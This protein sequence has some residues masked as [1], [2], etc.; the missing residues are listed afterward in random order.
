MRA[1]LQG[2]L[3]LA[4]GGD[5][6]AFGEQLI[7]QTRAVARHRGLNLAQFDDFFIFLLILLDLEPTHPA[8][9]DLPS[10]LCLE[11]G[12][13]TRFEGVKGKAIDF[14]DRL[15]CRLVIRV[16]INSRIPARPLL[17]LIKSTAE[18]ASA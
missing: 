15:R 9:F 14:F 18:A 7:G 4:G 3:I 1:D 16:A 13:P 10:A 6:A 2:A 11:K 5:T 12:F 8:A 17:W